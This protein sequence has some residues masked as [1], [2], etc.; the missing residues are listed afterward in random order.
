[1]KVRIEIDTKTFIRFWLV[2]I[3]FLL[4][5]LAVWRAKD[6]LIL[7]GI[8]AF[9][10]L[11]LN[12]PVTKITNLFPKAE[13]NR[14]QA[15]A[16]A[17]IVII[18][19]LSAFLWFVI[20][21][22]VEQTNKFISSLPNLV[23]EASRQYSGLKDF[24]EANNLQSYLNQ[25]TQ[26]LQ[27][28]SADLAKNVGGLVFGSVSA[29]ANGVFSIFMVLMMTFLMLIE[30]PKWLNELWALYDDENK[31]KSHKR[32]ASRMYQA[33]SN[34]V[35]GQLT[36][37]SV[38]GSLGALMVLILSFTLGAPINLAIPVG[39]LLFV[40]GLIPMFGATIAGLLA[41]LII[42]FNVPI[43]GVIF[44]VYFI[45]YQQIENNIISPMIQ[46]KTNKLSAL[47]VIIALT[48]GI[49]AFGILGALISIPLASCIKILVEEFILDAKKERKKK[50]KPLAKLLKKI[51][52]EA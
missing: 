20:P 6:A 42:G 4:A 26:S 5:G 2:V 17:Y 19:A 50:S 30:G 16:I 22:I 37:V 14:V 27:D 28:Y 15:T 43:A 8:S 41:S 45:I 46:A 51:E 32:I 12:H 33:V 48:I 18:M 52:N 44:V 31:M 7:I 9:L 13:K 38:S 40:L 25:A 23:E 21:P 47:L 34:F 1:M 36:V 49:Y 11:A 29:I 24:V 35:N 10:A 39:V 3:G